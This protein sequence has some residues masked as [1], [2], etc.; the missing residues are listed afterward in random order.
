MGQRR[1]TCWQGWEESGSEGSWKRR[2]DSTWS[3]QRERALAVE[4]GAD[5]VLGRRF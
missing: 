1:C 5:G 4:G 3:A 2:W